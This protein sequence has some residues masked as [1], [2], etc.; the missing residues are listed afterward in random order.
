MHAGAGG[1]SVKYPVPSLPD[2]D[3][4]SAGL[5]KGYAAVWL[6]LEP[7]S[8]PTG[9]TSELSVMLNQQLTVDPTGTLL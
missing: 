1:G 2:A 6:G 7:A 4:L 5:L 3:E 8:E 9:S